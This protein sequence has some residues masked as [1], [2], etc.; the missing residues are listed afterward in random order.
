[1]KKSMRLFD[2]SSSVRH[3]KLLPILEG[4][5]PKEVAKNVNNLLDYSFK[6]S[7]SKF[8]L[9]MGLEG[10]SDFALQVKSREVWNAIGGMSSLIEKFPTHQRYASGMPLDLY[11]FLFGKHKEYELS[12]EE[13]VFEEILSLYLRVLN[14][15]CHNN[16]SNGPYDGNV[17]H[18]P[19]EKEHG[20][21][22]FI[23]ALYLL[24]KGKVEDD[25]VTLTQKLQWSMG[26][27][28]HDI[29]RLV[30]SRKE[31]GRD[32]GHADHHSPGRILLQIFGPEVFFFAEL[33]TLAKV[34]LQGISP[35]YRAI[36]TPESSQS[37]QQQASPKALKEYRQILENYVDPIAYCESAM[38]LRLLCDDAAKQNSGI[39]PLNRYP[40]EPKQRM[41]LFCI[42]LKTHIQNA[43]S[44]G[45]KPAAIEMDLYAQI[46][47]AVSL[48]KQQG[49][50]QNSRN[51][52]LYSVFYKYVDEVAGES[53]I[54]SV[55]FKR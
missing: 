50:Q 2:C 22:A 49:A 20:E 39:E 51:S 46:M 31:E 15:I 24:F 7:Q 11:K 5:T 26:A 34:L 13:K 55:S 18:G 47:Q 12:L 38:I 27:Y 43:L 17:K 35:S 30:Q 48:L 54:V 37:L 53:Q 36:L 19:T 6:E 10:M 25:E 44:Q 29:G 28:L 33:H 21:Q 32:A 1:M 52:E 41:E 3:F 45:K 4:I 42:C 8:Q 40:I 23:N 14:D 16:I 9:S